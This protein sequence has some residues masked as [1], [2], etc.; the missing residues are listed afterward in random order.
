[1]KAQTTRR[2][3]LKKMLY[4]GCGTALSPLASF[5]C[6]SHSEFDLIIR[7]GTIFDGTGT[8]P[9]IHDIGITGDKI[10]G[11]GDLAGA[12]ARTIL[13]AVGMYVSPGFIDIHSHTDTG[14]IE[15]PR[16]ESKLRQGVTLDI[17]GNCGSS[18]FPGKIEGI[19]TLTS[20]AE[21]TGYGDFIDRLHEQSFAL[22]FASYAG[23]GTI[24]RLVLG[25]EAREPDA[26]E[27]AMMKDLVRMA[28]EQGSMGLSTGLEYRPSG[29]AAREEVIELCKVVTEFNGVYATHMRSEDEHLVEA[30][31]E[32]IYTAR[33]SGVSLQISHLKA[34]GKPN[35]HKVDTVLNLIENARNDG[36]NV[37][38]DRYPYTAYS[39]GMTLFYPGWALE[40]STSAFIER[41]KQN[42][43]KQRMKKE[44]LE[45]VEANGGWET[46]MISDL[47]SE[48]HSSYIG[49]RVDEIAGGAGADIYEFVCD[50]LIEENGSI[51]I[52]GFGM[53]ETNTERIISSP[54]CMIA[55]DGNATSAERAQRSGKPHPRSFGTF[56]RAI[57]NYTLDRNTV[58]MPEMIR[59]MTSMPAEKLGISERGIIR[60]NAYADIVVFDPE[61]IRDKATYIEPWHYPEGI[62]TVIVNGETAVDKG[63]QTDALQGRVIT[64]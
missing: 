41:L 26:D 5:S 17:G 1:M 4:T 31:N 55:S 43:T 34:A 45:K 22:N 9:V 47:R 48:A 54:Y 25:S 32:A 50:L 18:P 21:C 42:E 52:V 58:P 51:G 20:A 38:Y 53:D 29:F 7:G 33:E 19:E 11:I 37:H 39:T 36:L 8:D 3:F 59:K 15:N 23:H 63:I 57:R 10:T 24:R 6:S 35:W 2:S 56:P 64:G 28:M 62:D 49:K 61:T 46:M 27:L 40:G 60:K 16:G 30:V 44:T 14:L 12:Q 13:D